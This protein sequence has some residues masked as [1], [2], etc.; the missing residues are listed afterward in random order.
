MIGLPSCAVAALRQ[1]A[2]PALA[3]RIRV[4]GFCERDRQHLLIGS[5]H[6]L[7]A[8]ASPILPFL[9][10]FRNHVAGFGQSGGR[11]DLYTGSNSYLD[12]PTTLERVPP[13]PQNP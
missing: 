6:D 10:T 2:G 5:V 12:G 8:P 1:L 3:G 13:L 7:K 4:E 11:T 9:I